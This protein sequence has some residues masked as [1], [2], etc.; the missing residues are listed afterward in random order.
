MAS[1]PTKNPVPSENYNDL[2]FN[3]GKLDEFVTSPD[4]NYTDRLGITHLTARGLQNSVAGALLPANN[5]SDVSNKDTALTNLGG[6]ATGVAVFKAGTAAAVRSAIAAAASGSNA[7]I[8]ELTGLSTAL[9]I[10]QGGTGGKTANAAR[11][12][13]GIGTLGTQNASAAAI[14]GGSISGINDL[15]IA[16][17]GTGASTAATARANLGAAPLAG[18]T[19]GSSA[20]AGNVGE[21]I[22]A[23]ASAVSVTSGAITNITSITLTPGEWDVY[24]EVQLVSSAS[25]V[26]TNMTGGISLTS[27]TDAGFPYKTALYFNNNASVAQFPTPRRFQQLNASRTIYLVASTVFGSGTVAAAGYIHARRIR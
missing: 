26:M 4:N 13:L 24:G 16:D 12:N 5:L 18:V 19:D 1:N 27:A 17:G 22:E 15:A 9:S 2:R 8:T 3:A 14:T 11:T 7:D 23:N 25:G 10:A 21:M 6:G 20:L